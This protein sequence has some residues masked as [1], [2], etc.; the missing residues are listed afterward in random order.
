MNI[1]FTVTLQKINVVG[2]LVFALFGKLKR[3]SPSQVKLGRCHIFVVIVVCICRTHHS[4]ICTPQ[5]NCDGITR[6]L[7]SWSCFSNKHIKHQYFLQN[8]SYTYM[9]IIWL[10]SKL[11]TRKYNV[12][13]CISKKI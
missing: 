11:R 8:T 9:S 6:G 3:L 4:V 10:I 12:Y 5:T 1:S 7:M 13:Q 2:V